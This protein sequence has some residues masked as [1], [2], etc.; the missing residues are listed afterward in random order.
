SIGHMIRPS[1]N[2]MLSLCEQKRV[3]G[4]GIETENEAGRQERRQNYSPDPLN[5][6]SDDPCGRITRTLGWSPT[7]DGC[8]PTRGRKIRR[9][10]SR[11]TLPIDASLHSSYN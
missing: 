2:G 6:P 1:S 9:S 5:P 10:Q 11:R 7:P 4:N 3:S 8:A